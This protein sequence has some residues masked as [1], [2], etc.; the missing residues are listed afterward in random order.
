MDNKT[1]VKNPK[2]QIISSTLPDNSSMRNYLPADYVDIFGTR[3]FDD[4]RLTPDNLMITIWTDFPEWVRMLFKLRDWIVKPFGLKTSGD[5]K[6]FRY[7]FEEIIRNG[8]QYHFMTVHT[9][10]SNE[11]V[12]Q[13]SDTHLTAEMSVHTEKSNGNKLEIKVITNVHF[14]NVFGKIYFFFVRPF[15]KI[16]VKTSLRRSITKLIKAQSR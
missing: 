14:H 9:K 10:S 8:G 5:E 13:L 6:N 15:H 7:K 11:V 3:V 16:I 4:E 2:D 1:N 12:I